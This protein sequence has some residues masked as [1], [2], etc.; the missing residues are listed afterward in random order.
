M[1]DMMLRATR[2]T[3]ANRLIEATAL[4]QSMLRGDSDQSGSSAFEA[5]LSRN[6]DAD[7]RHSKRGSALETDLDFVWRLQNPTFAFQHYS[8][9]GPQTWTR[10]GQFSTTDIVPAGGTFI[11][12]C[13]ANAAGSRAYKL[14]IPGGYEGQKLPL[15]VM[16]HGGTQTADDF[17]GGTRMNVYGEDENCLVVY[18]VQPPQANLSKCWNWFRP[19]DQCRDRGEPSLIVGITRQIMKDYSVDRE[20]V[21]V[22]GFSAGGAAAVV[23]G[24]TYPDLYAAIGVHS[25]LPYGAAED[26]LSAFCAMRQGDL[27]KEFAGSETPGIHEEPVPAILFHGDKDNVV[28]PRNS[29]GIGSSLKRTASRTD[30]R[31]GMVNNGRAFTCTR[32]LDQNGRAVLECW[33]VHGAGHAWSG[34][35]PA[36]SYTDPQGPDAAKEM[37]RFF[38]GHVLP[39]DLKTEDGR[40]R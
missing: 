26:V 22:A 2:L 1:N 18:P 8:T 38:R 35:H 17:A 15:I 9:R 3:R 23:L 19:E 16:L 21:Y 37:L 31:R 40:S 4:I 5:P 33:T 25:G 29:E 28:H 10:S 6:S 27:L 12:A 24:A 30:V 34:G 20:R 39:S 32:H 11:E 14:Y 13:Y 7:R 36:G